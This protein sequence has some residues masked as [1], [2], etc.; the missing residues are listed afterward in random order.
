MVGKDVIDYLVFCNTVCSHYI[1]SGK[2]SIRKFTVFWT[3]SSGIDL[4]RYCLLHIAQFI[5]VIYIYHRNIR[6]V[7]CQFIR[8]RFFS[9]K[10]SL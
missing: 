9:L 5:H 7:C 10:S 6:M 8:H 1:F 2:L 4:V 3:V